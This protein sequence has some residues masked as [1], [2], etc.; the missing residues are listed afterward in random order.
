MTNKLTYISS[1]ACNSS[2][3]YKHL[4]LFGIVGGERRENQGI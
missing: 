2:F 1:Y 4:R 3:Q